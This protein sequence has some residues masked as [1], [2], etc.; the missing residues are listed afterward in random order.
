ML[1]SRG[2]EDD[3]SLSHAVHATSLQSGVSG[4]R[5]RELWG[6]PDDAPG[7]ASSGGQPLGSG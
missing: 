6:P 7:T 3:L 4:R 1:G 5:R 2:L